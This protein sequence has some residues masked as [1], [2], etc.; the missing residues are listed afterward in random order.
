M[1]QIDRFVNSWTRD[2]SYLWMTLAAPKGHKTCN[3]LLII[4]MCNS[5]I[6]FFTYQS[7][8][9]LFNIN[10]YYV[11]VWFGKQLASFFSS[12]DLFNPITRDGVGVSPYTIAAAYYSCTIYKN[13]DISDFK[14]SLLHDNPDKKY[15]DQHLI[16]RAPLGMLT[17][18]T[19]HFV[20]VCE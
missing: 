18:C 20:L 13:S 4:I 19:I 10:V 16:I 7:T 5:L 17:Y 3:L 6:F 14:F 11:Y 12:H 8:Y 9:Y 1:I 15:N 2:P